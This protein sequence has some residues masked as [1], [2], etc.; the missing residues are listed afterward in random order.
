MHLQNAFLKS[1][2]KLK[3]HIDSFL[4]HQQEK[5]VNIII[6]VLSCFFYKYLYKK[7]A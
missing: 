7:V 3:L 1:Y 6:K 2:R 5:K 4:S